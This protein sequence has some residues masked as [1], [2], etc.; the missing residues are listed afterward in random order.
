MKIKEN[1]YVYSV[2]PCTAIAECCGEDEA[3]RENTLL[4]RCVEADD[5]NV[6]VAEHVVFGWPMPADE[7]DWND[8]CEDSS[9]WEVLCD[10]H[11][12][13]EEA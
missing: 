12:V 11:R 5:T 13:K 1:T 4:V 10:E 2:T 6:I 7:S 9:A 8:M 3:C